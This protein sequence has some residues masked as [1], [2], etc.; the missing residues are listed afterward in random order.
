[1]GRLGLTD[2]PTDL[3]RLQAVAAVGQSVLVEAYEGDLAGASWRW[4][5]VPVDAQHSVVA[6]HGYADISKAGYIMEKT[7]NREPYL[8]HGIVA[9]SNMVMLRAVRNKLKQK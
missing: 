8:E 6:Y 5:I 1:M 9:G 4:Q 7:Y 3:A 2:R